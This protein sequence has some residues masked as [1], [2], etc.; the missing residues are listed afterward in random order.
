[1][2][3]SKLAVQRAILVVFALGL[4]VPRALAEWR[5]STYVR[6]LGVEGASI[7]YICRKESTKLTGS[8][9]G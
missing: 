6:S 7:S 1:M 9:D 3:A 4:F 5:I 8:I 2:C